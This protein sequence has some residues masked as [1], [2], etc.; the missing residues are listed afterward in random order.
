MIKE[1]VINSCFVGGP[2]ET[3]FHCLSRKPNDLALFRSASENYVVV[4]GGCNP[5]PPW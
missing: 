5:P 3:Q 2:W 1:K 4:P